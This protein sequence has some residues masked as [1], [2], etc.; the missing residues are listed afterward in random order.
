MLTLRVEMSPAPEEAARALRAACQEGIDRGFASVLER[1]GAAARALAPVRT[2]AL[3]DGIDA[4]LTGRRRGALHSRA[5]YSSFLHY[6][7][8]GSGPRDFLRKPLAG[9]EVEAAFEKG[10]REEPWR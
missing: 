4:Y 8:G 5:P 1:A 2:G 10:F 9:A 6:G 7:T 3:R